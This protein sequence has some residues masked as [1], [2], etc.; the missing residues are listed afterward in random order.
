M[1]D[2]FRPDT[3]GNQGIIVLWT[4][5][6]LP[7]FLRYSTVNGGTFQASVI[8]WPMTRICTPFLTTSCSSVVCT[9]GEISVPVKTSPWPHFVVLIDFGRAW[10][11]I[12]PC[13][14]VAISGEDIRNLTE[15][16]CALFR[17]AFR[18]SCVLYP[19][20]WALSS[21]PAAWSHQGWG[22]GWGAG[23]PGAAG[24]DGGTGFFWTSLTEHLSY[25]LAG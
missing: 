15:I 1:G 21:L 25:C 6:S 20:F 4:R 22:R 2:H 5:T 17:D 11:F 12:G 14:R 13:E 24:H 23:G 8:P 3:L 7:C 18:N 19:L 10:Y 16:Q 9:P